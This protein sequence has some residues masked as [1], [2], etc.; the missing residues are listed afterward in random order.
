VGLEPLADAEDIEVVRGMLKR[1]QH[2]TG[3]TVA[4]RVL[5]AWKTFQGHFVKVMPKDYKRVLSAIKKARQEGVPEDEAVME[6][7][8]G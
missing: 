3:S 6:A 4:G 7:V 5:D 2:L 1:H 8:H